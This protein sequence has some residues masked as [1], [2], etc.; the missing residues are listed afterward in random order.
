[1]VSYNLVNFRNHIII[2]LFVVKLDQTIVYSVVRQKLGLTRFL[3]SPTH[4]STP[5]EKYITYKID[6]RIIAIVQKLG[7]SPF[8]V[9]L[10]AN[11]ICNLVFWYLWCQ[12]LTLSLGCA[13]QF[14]L[15]LLSSYLC[16][17]K[18]YVM[19]TQ[20]AGRTTH[21]QPQIFKQ[22]RTVKSELNSEE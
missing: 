6:H 22:I 8:S 3:L 17:K 11:I 13:S 19:D 4:P 2:K 15:T 9:S 20:M 18:Y 16:Y 21:R 14:P 5:T 12:R 10:T 1:M 7:T